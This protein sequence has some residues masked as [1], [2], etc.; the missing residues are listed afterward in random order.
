MIREA[1]SNMKFAAMSAISAENKHGRFSP[2]TRRRPGTPVIDETNLEGTYD[3]E[4]HGKA[5][6]SEE[7][8]G[9]LHDQLG[10][11]LTAEHRNIEMLVIR[12]LPL[13]SCT[14]AHPSS[15]CPPTRGS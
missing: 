8:L 2:D 6:S 13:R 12:L 7:F 14:T 4:V 5:R 10:L 1:L 3:L 11:V 15:A 9:M